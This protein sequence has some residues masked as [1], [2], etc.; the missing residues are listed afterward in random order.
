MLFPK[1]KM[2]KALQAKNHPA[3]KYMSNDNCRGFYAEVVKIAK[4]NFGPDIDVRTL[5]MVNFRDGDLA[6]KNGKIEDNDKG[7]IIVK[8]TSKDAPDCRGVNRDSRI[9]M[10][11]GSLYGGCWV[12]AVLTIA[13]F[14]EPERG[15]TT[16]LAGIQKITDDTAFSGRPRVEDVFDDVVEDV[17]AQ[18]SSAPQNPPTATQTPKNPW[19]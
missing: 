12:R 3:G 9:L 19:E 4:A 1:A 16:Y 15:V 7:F 10:D 11:D 18:A 13:P 2:V 5:K 6:K 17:G 14:Y 8:T